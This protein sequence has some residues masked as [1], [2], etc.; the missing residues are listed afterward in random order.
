[1]RPGKDA[2]GELSEIFELTGRL[3]AAEQVLF[4]DSRTMMPPGGADSRAKLL[5]ALRTA[6]NERISA[7]RVGELLDRAEAQALEKRDCW[8]GANLR[9][10]RRLW[11]AVTAVPLALQAAIVERSG[12]AQTAWDAARAN[13]DFGSFVEPLQELLA[14]QIEAARI[15]SDAFGLSPYDALLEE[16]EPGIRTAA[17]DPMFEELATF[18]PELVRKIAAKRR[19]EPA[20]IPL[21]GPF[22]TI[23]QRA[24][25][26]SLARAVGF[27]FHHGRLDTTL[28]PFASGVPGDI[29]ITT[30]FSPD[31]PLS[32]IIC[33][34]HET[35]HAMYEAGL[36]ESWG[37]QPVGA[38]RGGATH[39]SQSLL[40]EMQAARSLPF[41]RYLAVLLR[42]TFGGEGTAWSDENIRRLYRRVGPTFIRVEADEVTY[43]LHIILRYRI[44][45]ALLG[46]DLTVADI[47]HAWKLESERLFGI[48]PPS[49]TLGCLQDI[50]WSMGLLGYFPTYTLGALCAAQLF[51]AATRAEPEI[52]AA[53][54]RGEFTPLLRWARQNVHHWA[55]FL[56]TGAE[57]LQRA[58]GKALSTAAFKDHLTARYLEE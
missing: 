23:K 11:R 8:E 4:W 21:P 28:H 31:D 39:E 33:I 15:K 54:G 20:A 29:R 38:A 37:F 27:D 56:P 25:S 14:L 2:Y 18:L 26:E 13:N 16:H 42:A 40:F 50:H 32:G 53:L 44:E 52:P 24:L 45:Q 48:A 1:M 41:L 47:P 36:P 35:G 55:S 58:T 34:V 43:P 49:H 30:R 57:I 19:N 46:G 9:E 5:A 51:E 12:A 17:I 10:M 22:E 7:P 6:A 3:R